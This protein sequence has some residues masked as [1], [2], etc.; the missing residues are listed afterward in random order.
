MGRHLFSL[1]TVGLL[2][3]LLCASA[4]VRAD[5]EVDAKVAKIKAAYVLNFIKYTTWPEE[6]FEDED[7]PIVVRVIDRENKLAATIKKTIG[8]KSARGR[9]VVVRR[10]V[11]PTEPAEPTADE[12]K[13]HRQAVKGFIEQIRCCHLLYIC[14]SE[15]EHT[16]QILRELKGAD[17]LS[18]SDAPR[19]AE[20][21]GMLGLTLRRNRVMFDANPGAVAKT[22]VKVSSKVLKLARIVETAEVKRGDS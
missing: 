6:Q 1:T 4:P 14:E 2:T 22:R 13:A 8:G 21:G 17:V 11:V 3:V 7:S 16:R 12:A 20:R 19:F 18:V 10:L 9:P 5:D 15:T